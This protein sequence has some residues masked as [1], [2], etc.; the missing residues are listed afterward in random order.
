M[1]LQRL[2]KLYLNCHPALY[3]LLVRHIPAE[4]L[5]AISEDGMLCLEFKKLRV[6]FSRKQTGQNVVFA[7]SD[8]MPRK[9]LDAL[10]DHL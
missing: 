2:A 10:R 6:R 5:Q 1:L 8:T 7:D 4:I 9:R 3:Y